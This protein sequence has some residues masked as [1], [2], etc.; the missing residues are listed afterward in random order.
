MANQPYFPRREPDQ[1]PWLNNYRG[2]IATHGPIV[3]LSPTQIAD[4]QADLL[5]YAW[6]LETWH[7]QIIRDAEEA[8]AYKKLVANGGVP[9]LSP[10]P[11]PVGTLFP[12]P[13]APAPR[14]V[15]VL[16]R[17]FQQI[18]AIKLAPGYTAPI[19][20]D[21]KI[22]GIPAGEG[23]LVPEYTIHVEDGPSCQ[24]VR[25]NFTKSGH[26][27]VYIECRRN[28]GPWEFL[29]IDTVKPYIDSRPLLVSGTAESREYRM[30]WWDHGEP[31]G[32]WA[33]VQKASV[34]P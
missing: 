14:P 25:L 8:T 30:R 17:L 11:V 28:G 9:N 19:G 23:P 20:Q 4:T 29:G 15:G 21:L 22:V 5:F 27:G 32:D 12:S 26:D 10:I 3:G 2:K 34:G 31:H 24:C 13:P 6:L 16:T 33:P 1:I 7:P 18:A